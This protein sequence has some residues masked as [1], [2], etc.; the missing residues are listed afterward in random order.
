MD[1]LSSLTLIRPPKFVAL[2]QRL[3]AEG[4]TSSGLWGANGNAMNAVDMSFPFNGLQMELLTGWPDDALLGISEV[5]ALAQWKAAEQRKGSLSMRELIRRG[6][7]IEQRL[8][9]HPS[10]SPSGSGNG[11]DL[12]PLSHLTGLPTPDSPGSFPH[13]HHSNDDISRKM[14]KIFRESVLL[15]L[16]TVM[17]DSNPCT[18]LVFPFFNE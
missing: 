12:S 5:S 6:D 16:H 14:N 7:E 18:Y 13:H 4:D 2:Y 8:R 1:I 15:Y 17:S 11:F 3:W 9:K 10:D